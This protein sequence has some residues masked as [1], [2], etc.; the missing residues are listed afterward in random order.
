[1]RRALLVLLGLLVACGKSERPPVFLHEGPDGG[2][3]ITVTGG[4]RLPDAGAECRA[5]GILCD[6]QTP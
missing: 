2:N 1:M 4:T 5:M 3:F 6:G